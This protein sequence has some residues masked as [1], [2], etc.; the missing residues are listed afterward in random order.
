[1]VFQDDFLQKM[2]LRRAAFKEK[3]NSMWC[4]IFSQGKVNFVDK[5]TN[6]EERMYS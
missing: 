1:M 5:V 4:A 6:I 3:N 2:N